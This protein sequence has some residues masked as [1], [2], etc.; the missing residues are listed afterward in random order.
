MT[1]SHSPAAQECRAASK[2]AERRGAL[3]LAQGTALYVAAVLGSGI[4]V[5]PGDAIGRA[6]PAALVSLGVLLL[7]S[8]PLAIAFAALAG[9]F[10][11][12]GGVAT[13][14]ARAFGP[15]ASV[16]T[17]WWFYLGV[18]VGIP[19]LALFGGSYVAAAAGGGD[20][21]RDVTAA[22]L[23]A[24]AIVTN[25][26]G[27][28]VSSRI[29]VGLTGV[30]LTGLI[31][32]VVISA[33]RADAAHFVPFAPHGW[34]AL[35]PAGLLLVWCFTG[36]EAVTHLAGEFRDPA[37]DVRRATMLA[38]V[39]VAL[40]FLLVTAALAAV[41]G[42]LAGKSTAPVAALLSTSL[43]RT[44]AVAVACLALLVTMG[45][46]NA[47]VAGIAKLGSA[48]GR[49]GG[50][51]AWLAH[52]SAAGGVP[53]RSLAVTALLSGG[54]L[55]FAVAG[56]V[57]GS[58]LVLG[59]TAFQVAV[60]AM[61]LGAA[62]RL[63]PTRSADWWAA[64]VALLFISALLALSWRYLLAPVALALLALAYR[65]RRRRGR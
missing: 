35:V 51:P 58:T 25:A 54:T 19:A 60:Y 8:M 43:G 31:A 12:A 5:L 41:L 36:W 50:A 20:A 7:V 18:P 33:P 24:I 17:G 34:S 9:R 65:S 15:R 59:C 38:L 22:V 52:G 64:L 23:T 63:L 29:Q 55:V 4:L 28:S 10:P 46:L 13:F 49:D 47:Y 27:V 6:G 16:V 37:R 14:A 40:V 56:H 45:S 57:D 39:I 11:D 53:R 30:L 21:T 2:P 44:S 32:A 3:G 42:P 26:F 61:G 48:L 62:L 1:T